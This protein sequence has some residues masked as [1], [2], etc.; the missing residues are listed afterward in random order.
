MALWP[1]MYTPNATD[2]RHQPSGLGS[3][4]GWQK[5]K[6]DGKLNIPVYPPW[7]HPWRHIWGNQTYLCS[8]DQEVTSTEMP[9]CCHPKRPR[10]I[11]WHRVAALPKGVVCWKGGCRYLYQHC[12]HSL[13]AWGRQW[14]TYVLEE[15]GGVVG[16]KELQREDPVRNSL[17]HQ[18]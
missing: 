7:H 1:A 12:C 8:T 15:S 5:E 9:D 3:W 13:K 14:L 4:C 16:E 10:V 6:A 11:P 2:E 18:A 17:Q